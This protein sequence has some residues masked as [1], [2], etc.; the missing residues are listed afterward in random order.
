MSLPKHIREIPEERKAIAPYNFVEL[1]DQI[2][3]VSENDLPSH[4]QYHAD[5][6]T[7]R[8]E[9]TITTESPL[10]IRCGLTPKDYAAWGEKSNDKLTD[11]E[12]KANAAF[13]DL[14]GTNPVIPGSSLRGMIRSLVEIITYSKMDKVGEN[15]PLFFR[16]VGTT[17]D[18]DSLADI[19][20]DGIVKAG[21]LTYQ[22][23]RWK[24][25]PAKEIKQISYAWIKESNCTMLPLVKLNDPEYYPQC[26]AVTFDDL[27][28]DER[29][30]RKMVR[31]LDTENSTARL[32]RGF[33]VTSGNMKQGG[34]ATTNRRYHSI[35][36]EKDETKPL[37]E[38]SQALI[39]D[40]CKALTDFQKAPPFNSKNGFLEE[41]KPVFYIQSRSDLEIKKFGQSPN[42][43]HPYI[44]PQSQRAARPIDFLPE[45]LRDK[46]QLDLADAI[47]GFVGRSSK[48]DNEDKKK[49]ISRSGRVFFSDAIGHASMSEMLMQ[50]DPILVKT[51][52]EPKVSTFQHYLVQPDHTQAE[53]SKL[54]HYANQPKSETVIRGHKLY[55]HKSETYDIRHEN[56]SDATPETSNWIKPI[57]PNQQFSFTIRFENLSSEEL[58]A[59]QWIL[60]KAADPKYRLSLGMGKPLGM[61]AIKI[62]YKLFIRQCK[63]RYKSLFS[64]S[65]DWNLAES[66]SSQ[67]FSCKFTSMMSNKIIEFEAESVDKE[68][69]QINRIT[70]LLN[71]LNWDKKPHDFETRYLEID[72]AEKKGQIDNKPNEYK[73]R[74]VLPTPLQ[75]FVSKVKSKPLIKKKANK[76][77]IN[78]VIAATVSS[79][80]ISEE[81]KSK[82]TISFTHNN[83]AISRKETIYNP[84]KKG[85]NIQEGD[86]IELTIT[87]VYDDDSIKKYNINFK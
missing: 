40:Y 15:T 45:H 41:G 13:F 27:Y 38:I 82:I 22:D 7:G 60:N 55:W 14:A 17:R 20:K 69:E 16:A 10:Y 70:M 3:E 24:I 79:I 58:G 36:F 61:G 23:S 37:I 39:E 49:Q 6:L 68:F 71:M 85:I 25:H 86:T 35:V 87:D 52:L 80:A 65:G 57:S 2:V 44:P 66:E 18:S 19:Y 54:M 73:K 31:N 9:C 67:D 26:I 11:E 83:E 53:Q 8:I 28:Q 75:S 78:E 64:S 46:S 63:Q 42:F 59:L 76:Y 29:T 81:G 1:P 34:D 5:R 77:T 72:R 74:R 50:D 84:E 12:R 43:R 21:Y 4:D 56:P 32:E 30:R 62:D 51:L 33:L 48:K 47:F